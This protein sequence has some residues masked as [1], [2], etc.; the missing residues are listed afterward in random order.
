MHSASSRPPPFLRLRSD[1]RFIIFVACFAIFTHLFFYGMLVPVMPT[2]LTERAGVRQEDLQ[3]WNS[4]LQAIYGGTTLVT[5]PIAGWF[6]DR[7]GTRRLPFLLC[8]LCLAVATALLAVGT[9]IGL[10]IA[11]RILHGA[12]SGM[13]WTVCLALLSD[14]VGEAGIGHAVGIIG[15]PMSVGPIVGPLLGGVIYAYG[16][17]YA[18]FGLMF[19]LIAIDAVLRLVM[20][21]KRVAQEWLETEPVQIEGAETHVTTDVRRPPR[22]LSRLL[23]SSRM[24]VALVGGL[25]Q[26]SLNVAFDSTL[27]L[28]VHDIFGWQQTGQGLIFIAILVPSLL[29]PVFGTITDKYQQGR[30]LLAAG[31]CLLAAP[32]YALLRL[33]IHNTLEQKILLC[34]LLVLIGLAM[35]MAMPAIIAEIGATV[36]DMEKNDLQASEGTVVAMGWSLVNAA[37]A[38]GCM[39]GPLFAGLIRQAAG[40]QTTTWC[41]GLLS[42]VTGLFLLLF[43]GGWVGGR[44]PASF[45]ARVVKE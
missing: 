43:L 28:V 9:N 44:T 36:A 12:S 1:T 31:G 23:L 42:G 38:A 5:S 37:Y 22:P 15:I 14:T 41:L 35:A 21:E 30:R 10:W 11:G 40:W 39:L 2:A 6:T 25:L 45:I 3:K 24:L 18:V 4:I 26:S 17:Y 33:V 16:G 32:V 34:A 29:Q 27:P 7:M 20:I 8:L 13:L 19:A